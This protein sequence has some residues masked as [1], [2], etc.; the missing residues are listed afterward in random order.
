MTNV[1]VQSRFDPR[2]PPRDGKRGQ[3]GNS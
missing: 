1:G 2:F 3:E